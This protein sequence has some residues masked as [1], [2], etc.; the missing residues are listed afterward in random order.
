MWNT[1]ENAKKLIIT[2][3]YLLRQYLIRSLSILISK[4]T[5]ISIIM[6]VLAL[7]RHTY[8]LDESLPRYRRSTVKTQFNNIVKNDEIV[9]Y[10]LIS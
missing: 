9:L 1:P 7:I 5:C 2:S 6:T 8:N 3:Y 10:V 4:S